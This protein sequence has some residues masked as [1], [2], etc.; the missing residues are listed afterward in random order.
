M[1]ADIS[2]RCDTI[3]EFQ[4]SDERALTRNRHMKH[5]SFR[6][7]KDDRDRVADPR[8][9]VLGW[10]NKEKKRRLADAIDSLK[11]QL[12]QID[13]WI[14]QLEESAK[15]LRRRV[16]SLEEADRIRSF[17]EIDFVAACAL[18]IDDPVMSCFGQTGS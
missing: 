5:N 10:N 14:A 7:E 11:R 16:G 18:G 4:R 3:E 17:V 9:F 6:H 15:Q 13:S 2:K 12:S 8:H 1:L